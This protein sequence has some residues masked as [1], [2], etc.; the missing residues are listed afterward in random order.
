MLFWHHP[1][2]RINFKIRYSSSAWKTLSDAPH[3]N[4][5]RRIRRFTHSIFYTIEL[6]YIRYFYE[7]IELSNV[8]EYILEKYGNQKIQNEK[9]QSCY[10]ISIYSR[11]HKQILIHFKVI[12]FNLIKKLLTASTSPGDSRVENDSPKCKN[13]FMKY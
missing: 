1:G 9:G 7:T 3:H 12:I 10:Y 8:L 5:N 11:T 4:V 2:G 13:N 6:L